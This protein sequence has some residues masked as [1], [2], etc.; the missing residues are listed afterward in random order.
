[1]NHKVEVPPFHF[2]SFPFHFQFTSQSFF[3]SS[4]II[5]QSISSSESIHIPEL[6]PPQP[7]VPPPSIPLHIIF[8]SLNC[9]SCPPELFLLRVNSYP[10]AFFHII[11][12]VCYRHTTYSS[13]ASTSHHFSIS[14]VIRV[15]ELFPF[16]RPGVLYRHTTYSSPPFNCKLMSQTPDLFL[17]CHPFKLVRI[18]LG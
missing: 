13:P 14:I 2:I 5:S 4:Q 10:K 9:N 3:S 11:A 18:G 15:P 6:F 12:P 1:V 16:H 8:S 7:R 17:L